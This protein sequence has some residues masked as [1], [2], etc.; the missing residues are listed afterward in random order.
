MRRVEET[1]NVVDEPYTGPERRCP[2]D[3][4][5]R[6]HTS[7]WN[8]HLKR[9]EKKPTRLQRARNFLAERAIF[10]PEWQIRR[11]EDG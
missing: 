6:P 7:V 5:G 10:H 11:R 2:T 8:E 4:Y 9:W 1:T 3:L